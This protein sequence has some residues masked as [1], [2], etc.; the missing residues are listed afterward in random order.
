MNIQTKEEKEKKEKKEE[1]DTLHYDLIQEEII[2]LAKL[3]NQQNKKEINALIC[4][5]LYNIFYI[6]EDIRYI[7]IPYKLIFH[8][9][10][11]DPDISYSILSGFIH[12]GQSQQGK[13]YK[14]ML[15]YFVIEAFNSL[16]KLEGW[17]ILKPCIIILKKNIR[18]LIHEPILKHIVI[19]IVMQLAKERDDITPISNLCYN[20][21]REKSFTWGWFSYYIAN[22]LHSGPSKLGPSKLGQKQLRQN[23]MVYRKLI[24]KLR[25]NYVETVTPPPVDNLILPFAKM[26]EEWKSILTILNSEE[27][28]WASDMISSLSS[29]EEEGEEKVSVSIPE[30]EAQAEAAEVQAEVQAEAAEAAEVQAEVQ[31]QIEPNPEP[32]PEPEPNPEPNPEPAQTQQQT[33][34]KKNNSWLY[35]FFGW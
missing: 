21:P 4:N 30:A 1:E 29:S 15:D 7:S 8:S 17:S 32:E 20:L 12:F 11:Q 35:S 5:M 24:T 14:P 6:Y 33:E 19:T 2:T 3:I 22:A 10:K 34:E 9:Y 13:Q 16:L 26:E 31:A 28:I 25:K 23:M 27:Y 18:K